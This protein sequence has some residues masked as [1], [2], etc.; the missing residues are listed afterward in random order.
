MADEDVPNPPST[1]RESASGSEASD[2]QLG[3][4][5]GRRLRVLKHVHQPT[6]IPPSLPPI[7]LVVGHP[8]ARSPPIGDED[9]P[10]PPVENVP[11]HVFAEP[12]DIAADPELQIPAQPPRPSLRHRIAQKIKSR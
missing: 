7:A 8:P 9:P 1:P 5:G 11:A 4:S 3:S 12:T 6:N 2:V 10:P